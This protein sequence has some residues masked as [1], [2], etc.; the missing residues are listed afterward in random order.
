MLFVAV[1]EKRASFHF[2]A[3][4]AYRTD[5]AF[6][7]KTVSANRTI[8]FNEE[9]S[10]QN[11]EC[12]AG[13]GCVDNNVPVLGIG[14]N[15][16]RECDGRIC[17]YAFPDFNKGAVLFSPR[18]FFP[19]DLCVVNNNIPWS[20]KERIVFRRSFALN[21]SAHEFVGGKRPSID[22]DVASFAIWIIV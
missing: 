21:E 7:N 9:R 16:A 10:V 1:S 19:Q 22:T 2:P 15:I 4:F 6:G 13:K 14:Y 20:I 11:R 17:P 8:F 12:P 3:E 5:G 18:N